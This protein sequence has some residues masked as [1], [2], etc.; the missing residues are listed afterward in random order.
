VGRWLLVGLLAVLAA[1][2]AH[3]ADRASEA[4]RLTQQIR[5]MP[6]VLAANSD[7]ADNVAQGPVSVQL[8]AN[9]ADGMTGDQ[10]AALVSRYLDGLHAGDYAGYRVGLEIR[11]GTSVFT[12]DSVS[13]SITNGEEIVSQASSWAALRDQLPG[14]AVTL[15]AAV[16]HPAV[17]VG[18]SGGPRSQAWPPDSGHG[19][20]GTIQLGD[21]TDYTAVTAAVSTLASNFP[22]LAGADWTIS[23]GREHPAEVKTSKRL[24]TPQEMDVWAKVNVDQAIAHADVLVVNGNPIAPVWI[25]EKT[26]SHDVGD[27]LRLAQAHLPIAATLPAPVL[28]T[29]T[30]QYQGRF[31]FNVR[32]GGPVT[33]AIAGCVARTYLPGPAEQALIATYER[34]RH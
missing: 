24:P 3:R 6:A 31:D 7:V 20:S 16:T 29:A 21:S 8:S 4:D 5:A 15:H 25:S 13:P 27:A 32:A 33:I 19:S 2:S 26:E 23:A 17:A 11:R 1:C 18:A 10:A 34:C 30:D 28:Y 22:Q 9:V 12:V 14:A